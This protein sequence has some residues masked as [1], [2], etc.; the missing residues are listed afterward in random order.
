MV[1]HEKHEGHEEKLTKNYGQ[2]CLCDA[3][4]QGGTTEAILP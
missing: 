1:Y 2:P 3:R 4:R